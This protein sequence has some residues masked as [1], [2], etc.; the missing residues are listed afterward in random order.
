MRS[1]RR[2]AGFAALAVGGLIAAGLTACGG[3]TV[4]TD[5][6]L[7][8]GDSIAAMSTDAIERAVRQDGWDATIVARGGSDI[9]YWIPRVRAFTRAVKPG[10]VIVELGTNQ[11]GDE[12][13]VTPLVD[14]IM[15]RLRDVP[16]VIWLNVQEGKRVLGKP[17]P[18]D[19]PGVNRALDDATTRFANLRVADFNEFF[20]A[21]AP[22]HAADGLHPNAAGQQAIGDFVAQ[23][24]RAVQRTTPTTAPPPGGTGGPATT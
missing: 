19:A 11:R 5:R 14:A 22:W 4:R 20:A 2:S 7:V 18:P 3:T 17:I 21:R 9:A 24:L 12:A 8:V 23:Q 13:A 6:V 15:Q 1:T 10:S 16:V